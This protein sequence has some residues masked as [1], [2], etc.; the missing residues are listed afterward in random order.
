MRGSRAG[1]ASRHDGARRRTDRAEEEE[2]EIQMNRG[3]RN[4][5]VVG[6]QINDQQT[7]PIQ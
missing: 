3:R 7:L 5:T 6:S 2:E 1:L 4:A